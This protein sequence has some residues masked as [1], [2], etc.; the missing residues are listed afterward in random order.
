MEV[1]RLSEAQN[2][3]FDREYHASAEMFWKLEHL[4]NRYDGAF[5][6]LDVGG[7]NGVFLDTILSAFP[8]ANGTLLDISAELLSRNRPL[9]RKRLVQGAIEDIPQLLGDQK[10]DVITVNWVL[11]HLVGRTYQQCRKNCIAMLQMCADLLS[12]RGT[13]LVSETMVDGF[14]GTNIPSRLIYEITRIENPAF[15]RL[16]SRFFNTAGVGVCFRSDDA[17]SRLF[18]EAGFQVDDASYGEYW[19]YSLKKRALYAGLMLASQ[20]HR[21][22]FLR[23][24]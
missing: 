23:R 5:S 19:P 9:P 13:L 3:S 24:N 18:K 4:A 11:H 8:K 22:F 10:F 15:T 20:R 14:F 1:V 17:W 12:E 7:G 16:S 21:H 6:I 2:S